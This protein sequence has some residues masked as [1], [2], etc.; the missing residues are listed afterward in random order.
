M[1]ISCRTGVLLVWAGFAGFAGRGAVCAAQT[2]TE[3]KPERLSLSAAIEEARRSP[4]HAVAGVARWESLLRDS[5]IDGAQTPTRPRA[6]PQLAPVDK[7]VPALVVP[8]ALV[9]G[10]LSHFAAAQ[11]A[12]NCGYRARC[13]C[14]FLMPLPA[15]AAPV[16]LAGADVGR[17]LG[18]SAGGLA[19]GAAVFM[20][21][22]L[23]GAEDLPLLTLASGV[24]HALIVIGGVR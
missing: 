20:L 21:A 24:T 9:A 12:E 10:W 19:M 17:A 14:W 4:F 23:A 3:S 13:L 16:A 5:A 15:V 18:A 22:A 2:R 11:L 1:K 7:G 8:L 6:E